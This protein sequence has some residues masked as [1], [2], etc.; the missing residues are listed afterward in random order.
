M[1]LYSTVSNDRYYLGLN[2]FGTP[3]QLKVSCKVKL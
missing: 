3:F 1:F 2:S